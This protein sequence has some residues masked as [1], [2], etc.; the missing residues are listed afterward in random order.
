MKRTYTRCRGQR[1]YEPQSWADEQEEL[2]LIREQ[3]KQRAQ[4]KPPASP[5]PT[6]DTTQART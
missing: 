4:D 2:R 5:P 1:V 6:T 3:Q